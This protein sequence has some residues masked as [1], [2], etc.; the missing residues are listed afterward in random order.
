MKWSK[1]LKIQVHCFFISM[2][3]IDVAFNIVLYGDQHWTDW[4]V[5]AISYPLIYAM[6]AG[7]WY[8]HIQYDHFIRRVFPT[9]KQTGKRIIYKA[10]TNVL[11]MTPS[12][13]FILWVYDSFHILGYH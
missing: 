11:V 6:G 9:L 13:L 2:P 7:S 10:F 4:R 3:I 5:W 12:V 8:M 1:P